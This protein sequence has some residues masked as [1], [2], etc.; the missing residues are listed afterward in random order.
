MLPL[1]LP[2]DPIAGGEGG[3]GIGSCWRSKDKV[4]FFLP[5]AWLRWVRLF[6]QMRSEHPIH[7]IWWG[8]DLVFVFSPVFQERLEMGWGSLKGHAA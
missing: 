7:S 2:E 5:C 6:K 3:D 8:Q 1:G 4:Q